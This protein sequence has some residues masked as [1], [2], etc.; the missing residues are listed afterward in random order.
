[1]K[2]IFVFLFVMLFC[3]AALVG[4]SPQQVSGFLWLKEKI[5]ARKN[6]STR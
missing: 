5:G 4:C 2:K 1:M 6:A 3:S